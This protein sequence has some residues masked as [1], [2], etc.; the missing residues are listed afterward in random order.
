M[1]SRTG[2]SQRVSKRRSRLV[3]MPTSRWPSTT[4]TPL[5]RNF[6][7]RASAS[8]MGASGSMV[9]GS[10]IMPDSLRFTLSTSSAWR[11]GLRF[12]WTMPMPPNWARAM[13]MRLSVTVSM[14]AETRGIRREMSLV[15]WVLRSTWL[16]CTSEKPGTSRTSSKV[17]ACSRGKVSMRSLFPDPQPAGPCNPWSHAWLIPSSGASQRRPS[18]T[19]P[20]QEAQLEQPVCVRE[21]RCW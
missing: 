7:M 2:M 20:V 4:G 9:M 1:A 5:M 16:G 14:A 3:R 21:H 18:R 11:S 10:V 8:R 12:L 17:R 13:A 19:E 15:S 6:D